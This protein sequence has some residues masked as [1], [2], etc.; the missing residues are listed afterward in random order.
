MAALLSGWGCR[1]VTAG[2]LATAERSLDDGAPIPDV[3]IV[4][5][6]LD[7][8]DG[9]E[10]VAAL[11]RRL[12]AALPAILV[13]ADRTPAMRTAAAATGVTVLNKPLKPAML[14]ALLARLGADRA[15]A[16]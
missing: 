12:G 6:H 15:A 5:Y 14:R 8:G 7:E 16:E 3:A 11:R 9:L 1:V 4:D 13:T 2:S 10:A